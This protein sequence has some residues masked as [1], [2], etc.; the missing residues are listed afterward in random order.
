VLGAHAGG[1]AV[2]AAENDGRAHL[3]AGHVERLG[4]GVDDVVHRLHGE[5]EGHELDDGLQT[6]KGRADAEAGEAVLGDRRVDD[7]LGAELVQQSLGHLV[8]AL[9]F[10]DLLAHD[11]DGVIAAHLLGHGIAQRFADGRLDHL[12]IG[13]PVG[14]GVG[15]R[16]SGGCLG[17]GRCRGFG[18][19]GLGGGR[20]W[21][22]AGRG[23]VLTFF[24]KNGDGAVDLH[25]LGAFGHEDLAH[26]A[27]VHGL[28]FH[29]GLV[30]LDLGEDVPGGDGVTLLH[31]PFGERT[32]LHR[33]GERGHENFGCH[34]CR[35]PQACNSNGA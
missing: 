13:G 23:H 1:G 28:E 12:G 19:R 14:G 24:Y 21:R 29:R 18:D 35:P 6:A 30:G 25:A 17:R 8:G 3:A 31:Q 20:G 26:D 5:V 34:V 2:G 9:V 27:F 7:P 15:F 32:F 22:G 11:E 16:R 33:G 4:R 10:G